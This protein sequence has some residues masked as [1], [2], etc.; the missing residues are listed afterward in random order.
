MHGGTNVSEE[1]TASF[2]TKKDMKF[3]QH[4]GI[5]VPGAGHAVVYW[6]RHYA[7]SRKLAGGDPMKQFHSINL[8]NPSCP[9][10]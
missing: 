7:T 9:I 5:R 10:W 4:I 1:A 3:L 2:F 8:T 6:L